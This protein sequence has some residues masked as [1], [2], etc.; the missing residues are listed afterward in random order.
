[1]GDVPCTLRCCSLLHAALLLRTTSTGRKRDEEDG[2]EP[3]V[4][5]APDTR[6][7]TSSRQIASIAIA[8]AAGSSSTDAP[9]PSQTET[10]FDESIAMLETKVGH[11]CVTRSRARP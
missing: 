10:S 1:M 5:S 4:I 9:S 3:F 8:N 7:A 11:A 2:P 6:T